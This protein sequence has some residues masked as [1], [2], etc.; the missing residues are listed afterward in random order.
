MLTLHSNPKD[1][2]DNED[3]RKFDARLRAPPREIELQVD[4]ESGMKNYIANGRGDWATS[5]AF[6]KYSFERSIHH[7]RLYSNGHGFFKGKDEDL[8]EALRCLG[9]GLHTLEDFGAHTNYVELALIEMGF[10]GVFPHV[11]SNAMINL[12]GKHVYPLVT[13][14]FGMVDFY[15]SVLGE[16]TDHFTQSEVNEMDNAL[17]TAQ[18]AA[19]SS[20]PL[21]T[22]IKLLSKIPGTKDLCSEAEQLQRFSQSQSRGNTGGGGW[23]SRGIDDDYSSSRAGPDDWNNNQNQ[24]PGW[25][26]LLRAVTRI[27]ATTRTITISNRL[28]S[29]HSPSRAGNSSHRSTTSP[30]FQVPN[31]TGTALLNSNPT[32]HHNP[33]PNH[34]SAPQSNRLPPNPSNNKSAPPTT[35]PSPP[36]STPPN[37]SPRSTPSSPSA[38]KSSAPS[39]PSSR[40]SRASK[41]WSRRSSKPSPSSSCRYSR[42]SSVPC[43][44]RSP[45]RCR[46]VARA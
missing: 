30:A 28:G 26:V 25:G 33:L 18:S 12:H 4:P 41:P 7:G 40:R 1:Y 20:N 6:V 10:R 11:G 8:A 46:V 3:A 16:A 15:H 45:S 34:R 13:G 27:K 14:T 31:T 23:G 39:P 35:P 44:T 2:N 21:T 37:S 17:G 29:S 5:A 22:L 24:Q 43:S 9:Q 42:P 38:T 32:S 19:S 36:T